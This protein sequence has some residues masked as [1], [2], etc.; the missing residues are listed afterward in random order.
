MKNQKIKLVLAFCIFDIF[1]IVMDGCKTEDKCA[2]VTC[3]NGGTC[4]NGVCS[5]PTGYEGA[6]CQTKTV[7]KL[8]G[9]YTIS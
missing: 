8:V 4:N 6:L 2:S 9:N 3:Q 5:C 7:D 1:I